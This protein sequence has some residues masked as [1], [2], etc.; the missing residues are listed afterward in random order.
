VR[1]SER[2]R[3]LDTQLLAFRQLWHPQPFREIRPAWC[4]Q[5]PALADELLALPDAEVVR[6]SDDGA[7]A[8][9]LLARHLPE[10]DALGALG[11]WPELPSA[12]LKEQDRFWAW[13]IPGRKRQQI[14][15]FAAKAINGG[16]QVLDW[17]G[18]KGHLG[19][20]LAQQWQTPVLTLEIDPVLCEAGE[21]LARRGA[22]DQRF[23]VAD[24]LAVG[25]WPKAGDHAVALHAC[26]ELHRQLIRRGVE[27]GAARL[28]VAPCCYY[29]GVAD[30]YQPLSDGLSLILSRDDTRLAVTETVTAAARE[31]RNRD[32]AM[33]WKLGFDAWRRAEAGSGYR[34]F[35]PVP[36]AWMRGGFA[37]FLSH[38]SRREGLPLPAASHTGRFE[39]LGWQRWREVARLAI[40]RHA[41]R[42]SLESWLVLDLSVFL[43]GRGYAVSVGTF[44]ERA[45]SPRNLLISAERV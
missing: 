4:E 22:V 5:W 39:E 44:C 41:F 13:E 27:E 29:R 16:E 8:L 18:G 37:D 24:A 6:L 15:A 26:G 35:K 31:T 7:A 11:D 1:L 36:D 40:V 17:C 32:R 38:M 3:Q 28:D 30:N 10:V 25:D 43:E 9:A 42:R 21:E 20:L 14:E 23:V 34:S 19:R 2:Q 45:L 12:A 33:A